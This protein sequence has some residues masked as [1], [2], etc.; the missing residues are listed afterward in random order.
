MELKIALLAFL[1]ILIPVAI[2]AWQYLDQR[3]L[4][5]RDT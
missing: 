4:E 1:G 2:Q 3:K 5:L